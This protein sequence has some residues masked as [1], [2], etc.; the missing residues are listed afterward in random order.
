MAL[1]P[2]PEP[3]QRGDPLDPGHRVFP[4]R[5]VKGHLSNLGH[6]SAVGQPWLDP[7]SCRFRF[8][9]CYL[10]TLVDNICTTPYRG[11]KSTNVN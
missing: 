3:S 11:I 6:D 2:L 10:A 1:P 8:A 7:C 9:I 5:F 4:S